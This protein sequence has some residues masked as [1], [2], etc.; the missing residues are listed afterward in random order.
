[1]QCPQC[2]G[3]NIVTNS[4]CEA[5]GIP[6]GPKCTACGHFNRV[7]SRFCGNCSKPLAASALPSQSS[8]R[9]LRSLSISGGERKRLTVLFS[10]IRN[11]T[12]LIA[13]IDPEQ[14]MRRMQPAL[15]AM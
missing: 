6:L 14:A 1:M 9:L 12:G 11:S 7:H 10:D 5:C 2:G 3:N 13:N 8:D 15:N 4:F